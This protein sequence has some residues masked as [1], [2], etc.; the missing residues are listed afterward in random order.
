M[1][2]NSFTSPSLFLLLTTIVSGC[3]APSLALDTVV[4][5]NSMEYDKGIMMIPLILPS[6]LSSPHIGDVT[7]IDKKFI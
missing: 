2:S 3:T 7:T 1:Y 4:R 6:D 5:D